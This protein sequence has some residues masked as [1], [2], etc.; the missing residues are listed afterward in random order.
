MLNTLELTKVADSVWQG[1]FGAGLSA[2]ETLPS[3][4]LMHGCV[5]VSGAWNGAVQL[6]CDTSAARVWAA[7]ML[8]A[9]PASLSDEE[10]ADALGELTNMV[11]GSVKATIPGS[12][13]LSPPMV[14]CGHN[15]TISLPRCEPCGSAPCVAAGNLLMV[16]IHKVT[17]G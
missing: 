13:A 16:K 17:G 4:N 1:V 11:A 9:E 8:M 10:V 5:H 15:S 3:G 2:T 12:C 6:I 7:G 14:V